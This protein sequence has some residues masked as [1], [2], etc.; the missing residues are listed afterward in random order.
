MLRL[1]VL[2]VA[3]A[4]WLG[5]YSV[6]AQP[7]LKGNGFLTGWRVVVQRKDVCYS[8]YVDTKERTITC[9]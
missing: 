2:V 7:D 3:L 4:A 8:P 5:L 9:P 1:L 6:W